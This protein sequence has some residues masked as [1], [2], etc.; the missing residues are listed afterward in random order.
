[1]A[2]V[3][4]LVIRIEESRVVTHYH[5]F[6]VDELEAGKSHISAVGDLRY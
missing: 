3:V 2:A 4:R 1:M 5:S 6:F